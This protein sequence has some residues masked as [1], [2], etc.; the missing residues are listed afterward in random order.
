MY[1]RFQ[2][3]W[4][5]SKQTRPPGTVK[6]CYTNH[7]PQIPKYRNQFLI[8]QGTERPQVLQNVFAKNQVPQVPSRSVSISLTS[9]TAGD[10]DKITPPL[11]IFLVKNFKCFVCAYSVQILFIVFWTVKIVYIHPDVSFDAVYVF[12]TELFEETLCRNV[13]GKIKNFKKKS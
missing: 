9:Q 2:V 13:L 7:I 5:F 3:S 12:S 6:S 4:K 10:Q 11:A 8:K 1:R